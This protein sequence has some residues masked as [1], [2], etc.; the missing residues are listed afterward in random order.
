MVHAALS[1]VRVAASCCSIKSLLD[2]FDAAAALV[3]QQEQRHQQQR[4]RVL[5]IEGLSLLLALHQG[6]EETMC[7]LV[8]RRLRRLA[9]CQQLLVLVSLPLHFRTREGPVFMEATPT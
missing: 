6:E 7:Y 8:I 2:L 4:L 1:R 5:A 9:A 3:D